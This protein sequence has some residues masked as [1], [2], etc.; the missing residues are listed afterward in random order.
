[1]RSFLFILLFVCSLFSCKSPRQSGGYNLGFE[2]IYQ[3]SAIGWKGYTLND[4]TVYTAKLDSRI[5]RSGDYSASIA[6]EGGKPQFSTWARFITKKYAGDSITFSGFIKTENVTDG[7]AGLWMRIDPYI[8]FDNMHKRG[9]KG[10]TDWTEYR[11]TLP[12]DPEKTDKIVLGGMLVGK[13][14]MWLDDLK[15]SIDGKDISELQPM[16]TAPAEDDREFDRGSLVTINDS[17]SSTIHTLYQLGLVWGY[18]K[19]RHPNVIKG[20]YNWDYELFRVLPELLKAQAG[21]RDDILLNWID[22]LG[23][24]PKATKR[25]VTDSISIQPDLSW[26]KQSG[27]SANLQ[28]VLLN[29]SKAEISTESQYYV[30][31]GRASNVSIEHERPYM[32]MPFTDDGYRLLALYRYWNIIQYF[33]PYKNDIGTDWKAILKKYIPKF[34]S[35]KNE[36]AYKLSLLELAGQIHDSHAFFDFDY[37]IHNFLGNRQFPVRLKFINNQPVVTGFSD[38]TL[39]QKND[40]QIGDIVV[41]INGKA[42]ETIVNRL[43]AYTPASNNWTQLRDIAGSLVRTNDSI[44]SVDIIRNGKQKQKMVSSYDPGTFQTPKE[45]SML[46]IPYKWVENKV[47]YIDH[48]K[49]KTRDLAAVFEQ[50]KEARGIIIDL[51]NYPSDYLIYTLPEFLL[52]ELKPFVK[53]LV[54]DIH[55]PGSFS[56][57]APFKTGNVRSDYYRGKVVLLIDET[58]QSSSEYHAMAYRAAPNCMV[59][60]T[61]SAGADGNVSEIILP[62]YLKTRFSGIG[63]FYPDGSPTQRTGIIPDIIVRPTVQGIIAG[64]DEILEKAKEVI[65]Q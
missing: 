13:G 24:V 37:A 6:F 4:S 9:A 15:I 54:P 10:T 20:D 34:L 62:G 47:G 23:K 36:L 11:I 2:D 58:T 21:K 33:F 46:N 63:I 32:Q 1:M 30:S 22:T 49:L 35:A 38:E 14:K 44:L 31:K 51:R 61:P 28:S 41:K 60:G 59:I 50:F 45:F 7:Y 65:L 40:L 52:P 19:Y 53:I 12:L 18:L 25:A 39:A 56:F 42:V 64:R 26:I 3:D 27:F 8:A 29:L 16:V 17:D 5:F 57:A 48:G 55:N 43:R